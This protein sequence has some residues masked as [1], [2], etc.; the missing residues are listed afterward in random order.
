MKDWPFLEVAE[1]NGVGLRYAM[2]ER[3]KSETPA[4]RGFVCSAYG[5]A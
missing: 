4:S 1:A 2:T 5:K 3:A